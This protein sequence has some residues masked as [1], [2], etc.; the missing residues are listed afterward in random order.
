MTKKSDGSAGPDAPS[1]PVHDALELLGRRWMLR[2]AWEL[3]RDALGF[4]TLRDLLG[5]SPSVLA[6]RLR[7]LVDFEVLERDAARRYRLTGRGRELARI[8]YELNRWAE[9]GYARGGEQS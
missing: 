8:L 3:R 4:T 2:I 1:R 5:V 9:H 7:E 6:D